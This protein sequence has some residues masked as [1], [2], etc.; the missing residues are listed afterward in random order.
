M[1]LNMAKSELTCLLFTIMLMGNYNAQIDVIQ[2]LVSNNDTT[3]RNL[4]MSKTTKSIIL[5]C[6]TVYISQEIYNKKADELIKNNKLKGISDLT[7]H[8]IYFKQDIKN[9]AKGVKYIS[10]DKRDTT[11]IGQFECFFSGFEPTLLARAKSKMKFNYDLIKVIENENIYSVPIVDTNKCFEKIQ[12]RIPFYA[13]FIK[14]SILPTYSNDE[15]LKFLQDSVNSQHYMIIDLKQQIDSMK[16]FY[17]REIKELK[18]RQNS[19]TGNNSNKKEKSKSEPSPI[20][21]PEE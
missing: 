8:F 7:I 1:Q 14:E 17:D 6:P 11:Y 4:V 13:D 5:F 21:K 16:L 20:D 3:I 2:H 18:L 15:K 9:N 12:D 19:E 10:A